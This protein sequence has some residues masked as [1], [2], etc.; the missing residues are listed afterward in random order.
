MNKA[1]SAGKGRKAGEGD[2]PLVLSGEFPAVLDRL[3]EE[4][5]RE[6][7]E[8]GEEVQKFL[9][10]CEALE[11][12]VPDQEKRHVA[13]MKALFHSTGLSGEDVLA[14]ADRQLSELKSQKEGFA[15]AADRWRRD[16][17]GHFSRA[18]EI[19]QEMESLRRRIAEL[20]KEEKD[21]SS[22]LRKGEKEISAAE[23]GFASTAETLEAE[24]GKVKD[25]IL[26]VVSG[27]KASAPRGGK[28]GGDAPLEESDNRKI[29]ANCKCPMD[30]HEIGKVWKCFVCANEQG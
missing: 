9:G 30:W 23:A 26:G 2:A 12:V 10:L 28:T 8:K 16:L 19:R 6:T 4:M 22:G 27:K 20:E 21:A 29:C 13:A 18:R 1:E 25:R 15:L 14:A 11:D 7:M 17:E 3:V 24:I 5:R